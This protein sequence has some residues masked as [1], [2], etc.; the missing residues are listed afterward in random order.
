MLTEI[1]G[2]VSGKFN[3]NKETVH[4]VQHKN[5][6]ISPRQTLESVF[7]ADKNSDGKLDP[8]EWVEA[9]H[10]NKAVRLLLGEW[11]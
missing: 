4:K 2:D 3:D 8:K 7:E 9:S 1:F 5:N 10:N 11:N 6:N